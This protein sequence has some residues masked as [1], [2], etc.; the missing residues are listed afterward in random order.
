MLPMTLVTL[1]VLDGADRG[2]VFDNLPTPVTIGREEGKEVKQSYHHKMKVLSLVDRASGKA[3]SFVIDRVSAD[4]IGPIDVQAPNGVIDV[5]VE[6]EAAAVQA[7][8]K[9]LSYFQ[10]AVAEWS[11]ADQRLLRSV[12]RSVTQ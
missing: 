12:E 5:L 11:C 7:A 9:H 6:D 3:R 1:R 2:R 4:E 10:G 8:K